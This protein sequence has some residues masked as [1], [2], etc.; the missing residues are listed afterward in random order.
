M[1][2]RVDGTPGGETRVEPRLI[3]KVELLEC[4]PDA[5]DLLNAVE[6]A[7]VGIREIV[8]DED[9]VAAGLLQLYDGV[10]ADEAGAACHE[11]AFIHGNM[12]LPW[13][14]YILFESCIYTPAHLSIPLQTVLLKIVG[15]V[16]SYTF[17]ENLSGRL[18]GVKTKKTVKT[19]CYKI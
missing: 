8:D 14:A 3:L 16:Y 9:I 11:D 12:S 13:I 18:S 17:L 4:R 7:D 10:G 6:H 1:D 5:G 19:N 15:N 2:D